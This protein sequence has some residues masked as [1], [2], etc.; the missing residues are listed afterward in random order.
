M[1]ELILALYID[2]EKL[3]E[4]QLERFFGCLANRFG[5]LADENLAFAIG[6]FIARVASPE[7]ALELLL[8]M[9]ANATSLQALAGISLGLDIL[10]KHPTE[11]S[12]NAI[13][14][15]VKTAEERSAELK[16]E[17]NS[18]YG[19]GDTAFNSRRFDTGTSV[20]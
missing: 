12:H 14:S 19:Y 18:V 1:D 17:A 9:T 4:S 2:R 20:V 15:A 7:R 8:D 11:M 3:S 6:D 13:E 5:H 10:R 16:N